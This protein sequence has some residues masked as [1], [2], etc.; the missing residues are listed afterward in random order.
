MRKMP[1]REKRKRAG[2]PP[3]HNFPSSFDKEIIQTG[4]KTFGSDGYTQYNLRG[5]VNGQEGTYEIGVKGGQIEHRFF[6]PDN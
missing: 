6:R 3:N 2:H 5:S 1:S 4:Q